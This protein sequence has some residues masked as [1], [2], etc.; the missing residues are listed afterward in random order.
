MGPCWAWGNPLVDRVEGF[1][2]G[3]EVKKQLGP[4]LGEH[5]TKFDE[6][7]YILRRVGLTSDKFCRQKPL[8]FEDGQPC[9]HM[10]DLVDATLD[11]HILCDILDEV[12]L[13][14]SG[15]VIV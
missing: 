5:M 15:V 9:T 4:K 12:S 2:F 10:R 6:F 14:N 11:Q 3:W 1:C 7:K 8:Y 13:I